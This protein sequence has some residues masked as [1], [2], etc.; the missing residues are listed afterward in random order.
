MLLHYLK[1]YLTPALAPLF[2]LGLFAGG[3]WMWGG[4]IIMIVLLVGGDALLGEDTSEPEYRYPW[5]LELP[6]QAAL[7]VLTLLVLTLA[8]TAGSG[9]EDFLGLGALASYLLSQDV[10][11]ARAGN[12]WFD[13][14]G[15]CLGVGLL[16]AGYGTNVAHE[17]CHRTTRKASVLASRWIL[18]MSGNADFAIEHVYGH[19]ARL[20]THEDPA[21]ARRGENVYAF[22]V[23][24]TVMGH[25]SAWDIE[26]ARLQRRGLSVWSWRNRMFSGYAMTL[27][28]AGLFVLAGGALG[29]VLFIA[30]A[31]TA[32]FVLEVVNYMEHYGMTR[33]PGS[34]IHPHHSWNTNRKMSGLVLYSLTR[35]SA[36][37][38]RGSL[39]FY[40]LSAYP[41]APEMPQG[42]LTTIFLCLCPPLWKRIIDP[43]LAE[44]DAQ[45]G[46]S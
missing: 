27:V 45:Y 28:W 8:W 40:K 25:K 18:A 36:H 1:Y 29:L 15:A 30:Q 6:L 41:E 17:L 21:T 44:W 42:Y 16:V 43:K 46:H 34:K 23:R 2:L 7:P 14:L 20:C 26:A 13:Y 5:L 33:E 4:L 38:E 12:T 35:H 31:V 9:Q 22:F 37:H 10:F 11:A 3:G 19:H 32:K 39:P 24:S